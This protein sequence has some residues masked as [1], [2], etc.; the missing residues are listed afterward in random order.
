[1]Q[2]KPVTFPPPPPP[3]L[4]PSTKSPPANQP[5]LSPATTVP[6]AISITTP[7]TRVSIPMPVPVPVPVPPTIELDDSIAAFW[8]YQFLFVSQRQ[9]TTQPV[10]LRAVDGAIPADF[11]SGTYYL[12]GPGLFSDD[13]G[14]T[15]HPLD[16][17]GYLRAFSIDNASKKVKYM[18]KYVKTEAQVE[19]HDPKT[20]TWRFT[21]R[22]PFS[23]LKGGRK[24]GNTKVMK[25][26][27]NTSV[28]RWGDK[29]LCFWEGG[30]PYEIESGTLDTVGRFNMMDGYDS[31]PAKNNLDGDAW[32][33]AAGLLKPILYGV[34]KMPPRRLLSHYKVDQSRNRLL[35]VSCN[36]E[37]MLLP[38]SNFTFSEYD[39]EF[40]LVQKQEF[41]IPDQLMIHDWAFTDSHYII[42]A[43]RIKLDVLGSMGAVCG[44]SP[45][46]SA[47][48]VN[49]SHPTSPIYLLP[50][51]PN[52]SST[53]D[54]TLPIHAPSQLWLLHVANAFQVISGDSEGTFDIQIQAAA[55]SY[56]WFNFRNLFGYNWQRQKLDPSI[57]NVKDG[58][59]ELPHLVQVS[60]KLDGDEKCEECS[61]KRVKE[62][63]K[64]SDFPVINPAFSGKKNRYVYAATTLGSRK[65]LP[66]FP[67]DAVVKLDLSSG[68]V[69][70]WSVG[71][72]RFVGEPIFVPKTTCA[73][74][75]DD[76]YLLVVEYAVA[77][78]RCYL[79]ILNPKKI[80]AGNAVV[81]RL[82][83][84][85]HLNFP[86]GFHGFW[87][88]ENN[89]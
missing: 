81:A 55:C 77:M 39:S 79:V 52:S 37:D 7:D 1:M 38:R 51:F 44:V 64:S 45:M 75:E 19:E 80:G 72:R 56:R 17:H 11:P 35:T 53:R 59:N 9:E 40:K 47:L 86:L 24:V 5:P 66:H 70:T 82:E 22:G 41:K 34:F 68:C 54:W 74:E 76:G 6:R 50:R 65:A 84:P 28:L 85:K 60:I 31:K 46:I 58:E 25:N 87:A 10:T 26:V 8:D 43:N 89:F 23:V 73:E 62:W 2:A 69:Q 3:S 63:E 14:S 30:D 16:G 33:L 18:A 49:P 27:A 4:I 21:H 29:L 13:H 83:I 15:V 48:T 67:F 36:A 42:F 32:E 71:S 57:M 78:Q 12:T 88:P 61:V 20:D